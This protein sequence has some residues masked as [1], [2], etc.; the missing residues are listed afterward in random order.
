MPID[1]V[2]LT[3]IAYN[4]PNKKELDLSYRTNSGQPK[5]K[6]TDIK[7]LVIAL[8]QN[9]I[10]DHLDLGFHDLGD[11]GATILA[12]NLTRIKH[13]QLR[14]NLIGPQGA[15]ALASNRYFIEL[16]LHGNNIG[17]EGIAAFANNTT[18]E[19]LRI[20]NN[21]ITNHGIKLLATNNTL[22]SLIS[23]SNRINDE[24][25]G[26][27]LSNHTLQKAIFEGCFASAAMNAKLA[28]KLQQNQRLAAQLAAEQNPITKANLKAFIKHQ[29]ANVPSLLELGLF[30]VKRYI[31]Q[32]TINQAQV[33][34]LPFDLIESYQ[35]M[36]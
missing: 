12:K 9:T 25:V 15:Q 10:I 4:E 17:D 28:E 13:I 11:E 19:E 36:R 21:D 2:I 34:M 18:L 14:E 5:L 30:A 8:A 33:Q 27:W 31:Q 29:P 32:G 26:A 23:R 24:G 3:Q 6:A 7:S 16:G 1:E 20:G 22:F 35:L